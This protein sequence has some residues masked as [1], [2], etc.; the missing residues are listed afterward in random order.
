MTSDS[1]YPYLTTHNVRIRLD[2]VLLGEPYGT[3][4]EDKYYLVVDNRRENAE[5]DV[6]G[7]GVPKPLHVRWV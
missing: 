3:F 6:V 1:A 5:P 4:G 7:W 2:G